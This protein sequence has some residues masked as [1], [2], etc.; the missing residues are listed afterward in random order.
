MIANPVRLRLLGAPEITSAGQ[1]VAALRSRKA[2]G[3]LAYLAL[4]Q[5]PVPRATLADLF[6]GD[7][8][9]RGLRNLSWVLNHA[10]SALGISFNADRHTVGLPASSGLWIDCHAFLELVTGPDADRTALAAAA[11]LYRGEFLEGVELEGA[12][13]LDHWLLEQR[14]RWRLLAIQTLERLARAGQAAHDLEQA[15]AAANRL[16]EIDPWREESHRLAMSLQAE[17]GHPATALELYQRYCRVLQRELGLDPDP[18]TT[19]LYRRIKAGAFVAAQAPPGLAGGQP[20]LATYPQPLTTFFGREAELATILAYVRDPATRLITLVGTG[21]IGK[22]RLALAVADALRPARDWQI[23]FVDLTVCAGAGQV[24]GAIGDAL[25]IK[26]QHDAPFLSLAQA[27]LNRPTLLILDNFEH[28]LEATPLVSG[29]LAAIPGLKILATSRTVLG[30]AGEHRFPVPPLA[31]PPGRPFR[32]EPPIT[33]D[34]LRELA[35]APAVA[36]FCARAQAVLPEFRLTPANAAAVVQLCQQL[37]GLPLALEL[38]ATWSHILSPQAMLARLSDR[39]SWLASAQT[40]QPERHQTLWDTIDWSYTLLRAEEQQ[41]FLTLAIFRGGCTLEALEAVSAPAARQ[42]AGKGRRP[43]VLQHLSRLLECSLVQRAAGDEP[44]F[45]MLEG[46]CQYAWEQLED[47]PGTATLRQ[48][49]AAYYMAYAEQAAPHLQGP[50]QGAWHQRLLAEQANCQAALEWSRSSGDAETG[51]RLAGALWRF[52]Y[53]RGQLG[54]GRA[55][56][57]ALLALTG[58]SAAARALALR[59]AANLAHRLGD[60]GPA[61]ALAN[62]GLALY[63]RIGDRIGIAQTYDLL[64]AIISD[65]GDLARAVTLHQAALD[66]FR[67]VAY[68]LGIASALNNL[69]VI[70]QDQGEF[71]EAARLYRECLAW[72]RELGDHHGMVQTLLNLSAV[73][74]QQGRIAQAQALLRESMQ[75]CDVADALMLQ[76]LN[77]YAS[78]SHEQG[79]HE[80]AA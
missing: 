39:F 1:P 6:W 66:L 13:E 61:L 71:D 67:E 21:G 74:R 65:Q 14:E 10:R 28:V 60:Y 78:L 59:G 20:A 54:Q 11:A 41:V 30:C 33:A 9:A 49:H 29:M 36:L 4:R 64:G 38:A 3:V 26:E 27:R 5:Q 23:G 24:A 7:A 43:S 40:G 15:V 80:R 16:I 68:P 69:G 17:A 63:Q 58:G 73:A 2:L 44:R 35:A 32:G 62:Q 51:L 31:L 56:L 12:A 25:G 52:W 72:E 76:I 8:P 70:A 53:L 18:L 37:D 79:R 47:Y 55:W 45:S 19:E 77:E 48:R 42:R 57:T 34:Q 46:I 50:E 22:T 75:L